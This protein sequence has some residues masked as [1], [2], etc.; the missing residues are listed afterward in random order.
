MRSTANVQ[1]PWITLRRQCNTF[2]VS[3]DQTLGRKTGSS[4]TG[5]NYM[6]WRYSHWIWIGV[7]IT[8]ITTSWLSRFFPPFFSCTSK[9]KSY[10]LR[11][12]GT[13]TVFG[14]KSWHSRDSAPA[15]NELT[16]RVMSAKIGNRADSDTN[17]RTFV[18]QSS[19]ASFAI[20]QLGLC[21]ALSVAVLMHLCHIPSEFWKLILAHLAQH[22]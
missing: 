10:G 11:E 17:V 12:Q 1:K 6:V 21:W 13:A 14:N 8:I 7:C 19:P 15:K 4:R 18:S 2:D 20:F 16:F 3:N 9:H 5:L 22:D